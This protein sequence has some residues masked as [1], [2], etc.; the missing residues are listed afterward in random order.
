LQGPKTTIFFTGTKIKTRHICS[1]QKPYFS[2]FLK[3]E[4]QI[5]INNITL[6]YFKFLTVQI[7]I[8]L[9]LKK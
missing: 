9:I 8:S 2:L 7:I 5:N 3:A 4:G 6:L 1:D